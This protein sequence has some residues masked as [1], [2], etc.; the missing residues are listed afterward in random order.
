ML[1]PFPS[2]PCL[3]RVR[4]IDY[5]FEQYPK[6]VSDKLGKSHESHSPDSDVY[7]SVQH[8]KAED[9]K[10]LNEELS[11]GSLFELISSK[12]AETR[13]EEP[14]KNISDLIRSIAMGDE[15]EEEEHLEEH[16][17]EDD[18]E[19]LETEEISE[20]ENLSTHTMIQHRPSLRNR[21]ISVSAECTSVQDKPEEAVNRKIHYKSEEAKLKIR[22]AV[23]DNFLFSDLEDSLLSYLVDAAMEVVHEPG[24]V[25]INQGDEGDN[26]YI[27]HEGQCEFFVSEEFKG[28]G[29]PGTSFG[30]LA[31]MYNSPRAATV[32]AKT[33]VKLF[34][35]D[36]ITFRQIMA[37]ATSKKRRLHEQFL[38]KVPLFSGMIPTERAKIA[39]ALET[40][41]FKAGD[42]IINQG[43]YGDKFYILEEGKTIA[44]VF[45]QS[46][47]SID[48]KEYGPGDYFGELALL[49]DKPRAATVVS[50]TD[51]LCVCMGAQSFKRLLGRCETIMRRNM[52]VYEQVMASLLS[53]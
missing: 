11:I 2:T 34:A 46:G 20:M 25:I 52:E 13:P 16:L 1:C 9:D 44:K 14:L 6:Q 8:V 38:E 27:I 19:D 49:N 48:I 5:V 12:V 36:R 41:R 33:Q 29:G 51:S 4:R 17:S 32:R 10:Y 45:T 7:V 40:K 31:L 24:T 28:D 37:D 23:K 21:R 43:E 26:F 42:T 22:A 39:D 3:W 18:E 15:E 30:E 47:S 35:L 53:G 50:T